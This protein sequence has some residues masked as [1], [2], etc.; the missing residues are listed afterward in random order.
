MSASLTARE[1]AVSRGAATIL[2]KVSL[3]V[4]PGDHVVVVGP[5]GVGKTTLL[6]LLAGELAPEDGSVQRHPATASVVHVPQEPDVRAGERLPAYLARRTGVAAAQ[7][8][9]DAS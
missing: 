9:L 1:V 7:V 4:A 8:E 2:D 3:T 5:N 6:R